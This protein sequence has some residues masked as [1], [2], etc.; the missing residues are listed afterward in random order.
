MGDR[1]DSQVIIG[2]KLKRSLVAELCELADIERMR[3]EWDGPALD[4]AEVL[5]QA[6]AGEY[7]LLC[8]REVSG[9]E[10]TNLLTFCGAHDLIY[11]VEWDAGCGYGAG[12]RHNDAAGDYE[13]SIGQIGEPPTISADELL[14]LGSMDAVRELAQRL[15]GKIP[16]LEIVE[17]EKPSGHE[18]MFDAKL[19][20]S[21]RIRAPDEATARKQLAE[22]LDGAS[23]SVCHGGVDMPDTFEASVDGE[24]EL[25]EVDGEA[26]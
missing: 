26:V 9:G 10:P 11:R 19:F 4:E 7:L 16:P 18:F 24:P 13:Y 21:I 12:G 8:G 5:R 23:L 20:A 17:N 22:V 2:G 1:S 15:T 3:T 14:K 25:M 6:E